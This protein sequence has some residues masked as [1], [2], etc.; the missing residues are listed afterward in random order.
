M[1]RGERADF[2]NVRKKIIYT[3][4][5]IHTYIYKYIQKIYTKYIHTHKTHEKQGKI[6]EENRRTGGKAYLT[7]VISYTHLRANFQEM[8]KDNPKRTQKKS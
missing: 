5:Y 4:I 6:Q 3:H 1:L 2:P 8:Q 7:I